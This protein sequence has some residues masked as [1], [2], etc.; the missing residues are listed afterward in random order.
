MNDDLN[1]RLHS[2]FARIEQDAPP[3]RAMPTG[4]QTSPSPRRLPALRLAIV[5][6]TVCGL[7]GILIVRARTTERTHVAGV[8]VLDTTDPSIQVPRSSSTASAIPS[9]PSSTFPVLD[10]TAKNYLVIGADNGACVSQGSATAGGF[11][12]RTGLGERTDTIMIVRVEPATNQVAILS[13]PRDLWVKIDGTNGSNRINSA[14]VHNNPQPLVNTIF[15]NFGI[16]I[17]HVIQID[18]CGFKSVVDS[19]GGVTVPFAQAVRDTRSG[20]DIPTA[21]CHNLDGDEAL[22]YVRSRHFEYLRADGKWTEDPSSDFGRVARQQDFVWRALSAALAH[23]VSD[24]ATARR[25]ISSILDHLVVDANLTL[26]TMIGLA[27]IARRVD[28][29]SVVAT[30]LP[31]RGE[32][33]AGALVLVPDL[34]TDQANAIVQLFQGGGTP[35]PPPITR[36]TGSPVNPSAP[37][38]IPASGNSGIVPDHSQRC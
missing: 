24:P 9:P 5:V 10:P 3:A 8:P 25:V 31:A 12:D 22:A 32:L 27:G 35:P 4:I 20:L 6:A 34:G 23:G 26:D 33:I 15:Q 11:G 13:L 37:L 17:Q 16:P 28:P 19:I 29:A 2:Y 7:A 36:A 21:G 18:L 14:Y 38:A 30:T 1:R